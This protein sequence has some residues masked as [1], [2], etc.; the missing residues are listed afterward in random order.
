M[1]MILF[2]CQ[3][4]PDIAFNENLVFNDHSLRLHVCKTFYLK[5]ATLELK[6][7][8]ATSFASLSD[9]KV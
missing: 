2:G 1:F 9:L 6:T 3:K 5:F 8:S 4:R 7:L